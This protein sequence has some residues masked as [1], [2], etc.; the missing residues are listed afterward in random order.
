MSVLSSDLT[1]PNPYLVAYNTLPTG[2]EAV[3]VDP[4]PLEQQFVPDGFTSPLPELLTGASP[5]QVPDFA[6][7]GLI[8]EPQIVPYGPFTQEGGNEY[9]LPNVQPSPDFSIPNFQDLLALDQGFSNTFPNVCSGTIVPVSSCCTPQKGRPRVADSS[10]CRA[11][12]SYIL[13]ILI[14][15]QLSYLCPSILILIFRG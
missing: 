13:F 12:T 7:G 9:L 8:E 3:P 5:I 4:Y 14:C 11:C 2:P 1:S 6:Y 15:Y 10:T